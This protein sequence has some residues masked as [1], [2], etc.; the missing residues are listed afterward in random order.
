MGFATKYIVPIRPI[1]NKSIEVFKDLK[2]QLEDTDYIGKNYKK[3]EEKTGK[4]ID[5]LIA[6]FSVGNI[7]SSQA[8]IVLEEVSKKTNETIKNMRFY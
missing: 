7:S 5:K 4:Y 2:E 3:V 1:A 8:N 6:E